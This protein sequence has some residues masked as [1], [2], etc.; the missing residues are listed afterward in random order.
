[1]I[2]FLIEV[3]LEI[4]LRSAEAFIKILEDICLFA[5]AAFR[6]EILLF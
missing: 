5:I 1:M 6:S 2:V 4:V 3:V